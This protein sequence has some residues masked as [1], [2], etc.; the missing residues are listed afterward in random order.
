MATGKAGWPTKSPG[1]GA[2]KFD[3]FMLNLMLV[4]SIRMGLL[5]LSYVEWFYGG[6]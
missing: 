4:S 1:I 5:D 3:H 6:V 2:L